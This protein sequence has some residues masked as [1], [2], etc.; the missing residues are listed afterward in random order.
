M[1][2][3]SSMI[4]GTLHSMESK[5]VALHSH[6]FHSIGKSKLTTTHADIE[7]S[8]GIRKL[9]KLEDLR[10][11]SQ[12]SKIELNNDNN[13]CIWMSLN[14]HYHQIYEGIGFMEKSLNFNNWAI[15]AYGAWGITLNSSYSRVLISYTRVELLRFL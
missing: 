11:G 8:F 4:K 13:L 9:W 3:W 1:V 5:S 7:F 14:M 6:K 15:G 12:N 2:C 10:I